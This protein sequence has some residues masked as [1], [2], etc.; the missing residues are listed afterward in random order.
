LVSA[1]KKLSNNNL[2][3]LN[4]HPVY[5]FVHYTHPTVLKRLKELKK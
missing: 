4:P 5:E 1:L 3:N 2:S